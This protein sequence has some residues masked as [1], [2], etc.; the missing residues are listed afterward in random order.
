MTLVEKLNAAG[1]GRT[2]QPATLTAL[3]GMRA[4][5]NVL[6]QAYRIR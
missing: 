6:A 2:L 3:G 5:L 1:E 4:P